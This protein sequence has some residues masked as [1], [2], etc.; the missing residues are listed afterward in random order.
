ML[1]E[2]IR[3]S[4]ELNFTFTLGCSEATNGAPQGAKEQED[5]RG[6]ATVPTSE[7]AR[8]ELVQS[9]VTFLRH[10]KVVAS[11]DVQRRSFLE[12]KGLTMDEIKQ[13]R[14]LLV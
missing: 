11:S 3:L 5:I 7:P 6:E 9:A 8:E 14:R 13:I 4:N 2:K 12:N 1:G 10:P